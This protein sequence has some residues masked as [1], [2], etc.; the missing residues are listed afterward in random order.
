MAKSKDASYREAVDRLR[1][2]HS[3]KIEDVFLTM[4]GIVQGGGEEK[5]K[6]NAAKVVV[7]LLGV[8]KPPTSAKE[9]DPAPTAKQG[10]YKK[11]EL[12][13]HLKEQLGRLINNGSTRD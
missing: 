12:P 3:D 2:K 8:P 4:Y 1:A 11:P 9:P 5:D 13:A 6:V 10:N 7:S